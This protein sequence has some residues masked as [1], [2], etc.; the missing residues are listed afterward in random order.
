MLWTSRLSLGSVPGLPHAADPGQGSEPPRFSPGLEEEF[1]RFR[2]LSSRTLLRATSALAAL[3]MLLRALERVVHGPPSRMVLV[4]FGLVI[5]A[6]GILAIIAWTPLLERFYLPWAR[7]VVPLRSA[8]IAAHAVEAAA[9]GQVE[10]LMG[11]P[12]MLIGAFFFFGLRV[13]AALVTGLLMLASSVAAALFFRLELPIALHSAAFL[14][15]TV[16]ACAAAA[17]HLDRL[18]RASFLE[19]RRIADFAQHDA[20]TGTKNRRVFDEHLVRLW[21]QASEDQRALAIVL[22]DVD[23]FKAYNDRYGHLAGDQA[24]RQIAQTVQRLIRRPLD[25]LARY[26]GEEFAVILYDMELDS[27]TDLA[28]RICREVARLE[29]E[30]RDSDTGPVVTISAGIAALRPTRER[31]PRGAVQLADQ[32][33]YEAKLHGRNRIHV[34]EE[35]DHRAMVTGVFATPMH[36]LHS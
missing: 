1:Q 31:A 10:V 33:L 23:H 21:Q 11:L 35:A 13:R 17:V 18:S 28:S 32:A 34:L 19:Q 26:G 2:L 7:I 20:L 25:I 16:I 15:A 24:L 4:D 6:S 3:A 27:A 8:I 22:I 12:L 14:T 5:L 29:I 36:Q 9:H 30:H